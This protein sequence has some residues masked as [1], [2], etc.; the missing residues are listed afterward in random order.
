L[1]LSLS[2]TLDV[3]T[4][5][6]SWALALLVLAALLRRRGRT[7]WMLAAVAVVQLAVFSMPR[8]ANAVQRAAEAGA[9]TTYRPDVVYDAVVVLAGMVDMETTRTTG[10][11]DLIGAADRVVRAFELWRTGH[12]R[13]IVLSGGPV[14]GGGSE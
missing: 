1:F 11:L 14:P 7:P 5:P 2:K 13:M 4:E 9:A 6:L 3:A 10:E 8:A 12:V